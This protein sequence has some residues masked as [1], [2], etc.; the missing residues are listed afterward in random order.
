[1]GVCCYKKRAR[2]TVTAMR[3]RRMSIDAREK[4]EG[5]EVSFSMSEGSM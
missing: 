3:L 4:T 5:R 2:E 1:M